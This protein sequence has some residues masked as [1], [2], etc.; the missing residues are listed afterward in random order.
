MLFRSD[1]YRVLADSQPSGGF[2]L[3]LGDATTGVDG[4]AVSMPPG[5]KY[6]VVAGRKDGC[7]GPK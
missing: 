6:F 4:L 2:E 7:Q 3:V 1:S 5:A